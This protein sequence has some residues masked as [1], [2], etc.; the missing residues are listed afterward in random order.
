MTRRERRAALMRR[1]LREVPVGHLLM[2]LDL[3]VVQS[4]SGCPLCYEGGVRDRQSNPGAENTRHGQA[5]SG[6]ASGELDQENTARK[7]SPNPL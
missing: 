2:H 5:F 3:D 1:D 7:Y 4:Q 6:F